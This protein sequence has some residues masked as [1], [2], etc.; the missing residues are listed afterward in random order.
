MA[1]AVTT[2]TAGTS[3]RVS[4]RTGRTVTGAP[5]DAATALRNCAFFWTDST[6]VT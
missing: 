3:A 5:V 6:S 2:S 4:T 1:R